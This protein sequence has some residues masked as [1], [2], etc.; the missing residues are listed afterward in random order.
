MRIDIDILTQLMKKNNRGHG[1]GSFEKT[2][3]FLYLL[4]FDFFFVFNS[5]II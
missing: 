1:D 4:D 3:H 2:A 5:S